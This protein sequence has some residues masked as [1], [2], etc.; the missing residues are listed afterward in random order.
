MWLAFNFWDLPV[1]QTWELC[2]RVPYYW[3]DEAAYG[4][5]IPVQCIQTAVLST[6][7]RP[8][9]ICFHVSHPPMFFFFFGFYGALPSGS[10]CQLK[11][12]DHPCAQ[13]AA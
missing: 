8:Q 4:Y 13:T 3:R 6:Y 9:S 10:G 1:K 2:A 11:R 5:V 12:S 7:P